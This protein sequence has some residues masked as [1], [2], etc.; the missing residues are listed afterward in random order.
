MS[1]NPAAGSMVWG[2]RHWNALGRVREW[3]KAGFLPRACFQVAA[4]TLTGTR[5]C[6]LLH[7][8]PARDEQHHAET[9]VP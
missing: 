3:N 4:I 6:E 2:E 5:L 8:S 1:P 7:P 9:T